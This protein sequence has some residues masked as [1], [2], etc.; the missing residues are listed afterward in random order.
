MDVKERFL[1]YVKI[2]TTS[3]P[4][5]K[6]SPSSRCQWD[7][8]KV[9][10]KEC[11]DLGLKDIHLSKEGVLMATLPGNT[12]FTDGITLGFI[13]HMDTSPDFS[14]EN[15]KPSLIPHYDGGDILLNKEK[16]I[17]LSP[18]DFPSL[19]K[20]IGK[21]LI[22]TDGTTLLGADDKAGI[23]EILSAVEYL[24]NHPEIPRGDVRIA[25][26]PDEEIGRGTEH[27]SVKDFGADFAF[28]VDGG[29][30]G[31]IEYR[32]FNAA[33]AKVSIHGRNIHPGTAKNK[34][35]NA[36]SIAMELDSLLP[37]GQRPEYT[38]HEEGFFHLND[39]VGN[40]EK[41]EMFYII[42]DHSMEKFQQKKERI[43]D[44]IRF[45]EKKYD[46]KIDL[47][48]TDSY[49][50]MEEKVRPLYPMIHLAVEVMIQKGITPIDQPIRGGT[51]GAMLSYMGLP[52]PNLFTGG[53][54]FHGKY[55]YIPVEDMEKAVQV[56]IGLITSVS[57]LTKEDMYE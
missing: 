5:S 54:N 26:T 23:A 28:T 16:N 33:S 45:L 6:T 20:H 29:A 12:Q 42:R 53:M 11:K 51:D 17:Y 39:M 3:D 18:D 46:I 13:A 25:F 49:Y 32:N 55:E 2:H 47:D 48:L 15:V 41:T 8:A 1:N 34:M 50:N 38:D 56:I 4:N 21:E 57:K 31:S 22:V 10:E 43:K 7:L 24:L 27:F 14:G 35:I 37:K 52:C 44:V 9:L 30:L 19:K 40:V 36:L